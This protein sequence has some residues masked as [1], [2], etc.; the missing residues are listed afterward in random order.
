[1]T[2]ALL[3]AQSGSFTLTHFEAIVTGL[4]AMVVA[5]GVIAGGMRWIYRQRV[6][7][8][9]LVNS[10][11]SNTEA[12]GLLSTAFEKFSEKT[13]GTLTDHERRITRAEDK[14]ADLHDDVRA[15]RRGADASAV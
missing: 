2:A 1:M 4:G 12:T 7:S 6:S 9:N 8:Q 15:G 3:A 14:L 5:L 13:A 11:E 10:L